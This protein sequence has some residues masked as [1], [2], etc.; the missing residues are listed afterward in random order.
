MGCWRWRNGRWSDGHRVAETP[1]PHLW[2]LETEPATL[3]LDQKPAAVLDGRPGD[4]R[5]EEGTALGSGLGGFPCWG[6]PHTSQAAVVRQSSIRMG[7]TSQF[8]GKYGRCPTTSDTTA[9]NTWRGGGGGK[10]DAWRRRRPSHLF[11]AAGDGNSRS[12]PSSSQSPEKPKNI[13]RDGRMEV[14]RAQLVAG[15]VESTGVRN[16][17]AAGVGL[18]RGSHS[19]RKRVSATFEKKIQTVRYA[20]C[21]MQTTTGYLSPRPIVLPVASP[22]R[23]TGY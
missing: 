19:Q 9:M 1:T 5:P 17:K 7:T 11:P 13:F 10:A 3:R 15:H 12:I 2:P 18:A 21:V 14:S 16:S 4:G 22:L 6:M 20:V 23:N 8:W